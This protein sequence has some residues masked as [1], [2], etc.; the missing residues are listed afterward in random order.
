[1]MHPACRPVTRSTP[2]ALRRTLAAGWARSPDPRTPSGPKPR[3]FTR[4]KSP[5]PATR[6]PAL[7]RPEHRHVRHSPSSVEAQLPILTCTHTC[8]HEHT[9]TSHGNAPRQ[10]HTFVSDQRAARTRD[11]DTSLGFRAF[12]RNQTRESSHAGLPH[13]QRPLSGFPTL[14]AVFS[15]RVLVAL[16]QATSA[17]RLHGLQSF[18]HRNQPECLSAPFC[19]PVIASDVH[20]PRFR[21]VRDSSHRCRAFPRL[22][23]E[24]CSGSVFD[25]STARGL[26]PEAAALVAFV[27]SEVFRSTWSAHHGP[28]LLYFRCVRTS[29][30]T[31]HAR[32][33]PVLQGFEPVEPGF[34]FR[35][36][37]ANLPEV[38]H[39]PQPA[40]LQLPEGSWS[41]RQLD[42]RHLLPR[43]HLSAPT[44]H[45]LSSVPNRR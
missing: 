13:R 5:E 15:S 1:M 8:C 10:S 14:S 16:F 36:S 11:E 3:W 44:Y 6:E 33:H 43:E 7:L 22:T 35:R 9:Q 31:A 19:S 23:P 39:L 17:R 37:R 21:P 38:C 29:R 34:Y 25:T 28:P 12:Q 20:R 2:R 4:T 32:S 18:S 26:T 45:R 41:T 40:I 27:P 24:P 30:R 42:S